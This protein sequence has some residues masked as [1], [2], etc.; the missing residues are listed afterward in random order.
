MDKEMTKKGDKA[1]KS[2]FFTFI[3]CEINI[4]VLINYTSRYSTQAAINQIELPKSF[5]LLQNNRTRISE[6]SCFFAQSQIYT[7]N[8]DDLGRQK[9]WKNSWISRSRLH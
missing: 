2:I 8:S 5:S 4:T 6:P 9:C 7:G 1:W 3:Y